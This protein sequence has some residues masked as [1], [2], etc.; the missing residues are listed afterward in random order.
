MHG[1]WS[2]AAF[3][4]AK[5]S[6]SSRNSPRNDCG[7]NQK[8]WFDFRLKCICWQHSAG[9]RN[10]VWIDSSQWSLTAK[11]L[12]WKVS[13]ETEIAIEF[14]DNH[15]PVA[16]RATGEK[17]G[18]WR[19]HFDIKWIR[20]IGWL[21]L[22]RLG[23]RISRSRIFSRQTVA[24]SVALHSPVTILANSPSQPVRCRWEVLLPQTDKCDWQLYFARAMHRSEASVSSR[25][26]LTGYG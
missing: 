21:C 15:R 17:S 1:R 14:H 6:G 25:Q 10:W 16:R 22:E 9:E 19:N 23:S 20:L 12:R 26:R 4:V 2:V 18:I 3:W 11:F 13:G 5:R 8:N 24:R 7:R